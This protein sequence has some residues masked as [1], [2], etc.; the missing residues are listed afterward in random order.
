MESVAVCRFC[1]RTIDG[2]FIFCPWCGI[3][4][5]SGE[6]AFKEDSPVF[7]QLEALREKGMSGRITKMEE[8]LNELERDLIRFM[9]APEKR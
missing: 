5:I 1:G 6:P 2:S 9:E 8:S 7:G 3:S 4:R